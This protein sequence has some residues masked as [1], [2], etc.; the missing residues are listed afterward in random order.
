MRQV[1]AEWIAQCQPGAVIVTPWGTAFD[2]GALLR[3]VVRDD[4]T[5]VSRFVGGP[6]SFMWV[7]GQRARFAALED[8]IDAADGYEESVSTLFPGEYLSY[9]AAFHVGLRVPD[10]QQLTVWHDADDPD[11]CD[12]GGG[13]ALGPD[14]RYTLYLL[15][16]ESRSWATVAVTWAGQERDAYLVRQHGPRHLADEVE[17]AWHSWTAE[18]QPRRDRYRVVVGPSGQ[19][20]V[21]A[22]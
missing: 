4:R 13:C 19:R 10:V 18:G 9:P 11:G 1:P 5:A 2:N 21:T 8:H 22:A 7:R 16:P 17:A 14:H 6:V 12:I 15:H 20:I 3:L